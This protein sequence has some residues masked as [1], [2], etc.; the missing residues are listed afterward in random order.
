[1]IFMLNRFNY[2]LI[3]IFMLNISNPNSMMLQ[4]NTRDVLHKFTVDLPKKHGA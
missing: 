1:M 4:G 3:M 2:L